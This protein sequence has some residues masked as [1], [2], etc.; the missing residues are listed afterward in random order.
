MFDNAIALSTDLERIISRT[1]PV[2]LLT[3][4][5]SLFDMISKGYR[6]SE[7]RKILEIAA[8]REGFNN[9]TISDIG[10]IRS[11]ANIADDLTKQ[12]EQAIIMT[13]V[14]SGKLDVVPEQWIVLNDA[15]K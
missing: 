7:N 15:I 6:T 13:V 2:Q 5:K 12:M 1:V 3:D 11:T 10:F 4:S 8:A 14:S 9:K